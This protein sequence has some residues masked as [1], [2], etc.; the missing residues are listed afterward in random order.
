MNKFLNRME[1]KFGKCAIPN[2]MLMIVIGMALTFLVDLFFHDLNI[3]SYMILTRQGLFHGQVWRLI[4]FLFVPT[5]SSILF[6]LISLYFYYFL[7]SSLERAW[8]SF[9]FTAYY[10]IGA[11]GTVLAT[12][13]T[14]YPAVNQMLNLSLFLA[15]AVLYPDHEFLLFFILP[16]KV[17][18]LAYVD[19]VVILFSMVSGGWSACISGIMALLNFLLFFGGDFWKMAKA[20]RGYQSTRNNFRKAMRDKKRK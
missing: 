14:G 4:T 6:L 1:R 17:K 9:R 15:F 2:L 10:V 5:N 13:V 12:L 18:Y 19:A 3:T 8:G 11:L 20:K 16:V 7:G